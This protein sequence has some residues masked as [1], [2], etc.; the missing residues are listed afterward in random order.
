MQGNPYRELSVFLRFLKIPYEK[1]L[2][3]EIRTIRVFV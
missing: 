3:N 1:V 2:A